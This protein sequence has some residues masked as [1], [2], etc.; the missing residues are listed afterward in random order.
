MS[1]EL[2]V[3]SKQV[4]KQMGGVFENMLSLRLGL[5]GTGCLGMDT[6]EGYFPR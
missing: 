6:F 2:C 1:A 3:Y 5:L 4:S